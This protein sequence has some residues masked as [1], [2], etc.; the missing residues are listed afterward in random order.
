[1]E[2]IYEASSVQGQKLLVYEDGIVLTTKSRKAAEGLDPDQRTFY[3]SEITFME[4]KNCG[5]FPGF[6]EFHVKSSAKRLQSLN[7]GTSSTTRFSFSNTTLHDNK[8]LASQMEKIK[9]F[10][11]IKIDEFAAAHPETA[12]GVISVADEIMKFKQLLDQGT[13]SK[14]EFEKKKKELLNQ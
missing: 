9:V 4:F 10:I 11:Q 5:W 7:N 8:S 1:M 12:G 3:F 6:L 13:I 2:P 14:E